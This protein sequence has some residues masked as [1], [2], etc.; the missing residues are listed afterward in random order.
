MKILS[1]FVDESGDFG[2]YDKRAPYY[3]ITLLF[4]NQSYDIY[5]YVGIL[6]IKLANLGYPNHCIHT[7]PLIRR[8]EIYSNLEIQERKRLFNCFYF[9]LKKLNI[10]YLTIEFQK[11]KFTSE[12]NMIADLSKSLSRQ[13]IRNECYISTFDKIIIYY[14]R[15]QGAVSRILSSVF[16]TTFPEKEIEFKEHVTPNNYKLFQAADVICTLELIDRKIKNSSMSQSERKFFNREKEFEKNYFK[17]ISK[18]RL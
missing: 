1:V 2:Q 15:G 4:H 6:D 12:L 8:E 7:G 11:R 18:K 9:F 13:L 14:D 16:S 10:N 5:P 3:L 17:N